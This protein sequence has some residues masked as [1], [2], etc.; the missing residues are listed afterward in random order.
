MKYTAQEIKSLKPEKLHC[1]GNGLY[2]RLNNQ[3]M[4]NWCIRYRWQGR[5][6]EMGLGPYPQ[7]TLKQARMLRDEAMIMLSKGNDPIDARRKKI[8]EDKNKA[9]IRF[10]HVVEKVIANKRIKWTCPKNEKQWRSSLTRHIYPYLDQKPLGLITRKDVIDA[11]DPIWNDKTDTARKMIGRMARVFGYAKARGLYQ[12][13]NPA[14]WKHNLDEVFSIKAEVKHHEALDYKLIPDFYLKLHNIDTIGSFALRFIILTAGRTCEVRFATRHEIN[15]KK[16]IWTVPEARMKARRKHNVPLSRQAFTLLSTLSTHNMPF[17]FPGR[18]PERPMSNG[19]MYRLIRKRFPHE[20][21][22]VHGFRSSF[23]DWA[24]ENGD[25]GHNV[26]EF[27]LAH[28]TG[29]KAEAAYLRTELIDKRR[30]LMQDWADFVTSK[31]H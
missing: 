5:T 18:N 3:K 1:D 23:R 19:T 6:R 25:Y 12:G 14:L 17:I 4:G 11:L 20:T 21:F 2:I 31:I 15:Q 7:I 28:K 22:T 10:S 8:Y 16:S 27:S 26:I 29:T 9:S 24:E 30:V 13:E